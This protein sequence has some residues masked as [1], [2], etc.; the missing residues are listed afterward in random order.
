MIDV[1][2]G[3]AMIEFKN[4]DGI[5]S[6]KSGFGVHPVD[7]CLIG[8]VGCGGSKATLYVVSACAVVEFGRIGIISHVFIAEL[9]HHL[10]DVG[11]EVP[12]LAVGSGELKVLGI[13]AIDGTHK[14]IIIA[15]F[16]WLQI[17]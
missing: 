1:Y 6:R 9:V 8:L 14:L 12:C 16:K 15:G 17:L 3:I 11:I 4:G 10:L 5:Y 7:G 13:L 2:L